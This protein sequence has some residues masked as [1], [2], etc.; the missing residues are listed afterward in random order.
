[1]VDV[2]MLYNLSSQGE[3]QLFPLKKRE[4][5]S[6]EQSIMSESL[7]T[8]ISYWSLLSTQCGKMGVME[9]LFLTLRH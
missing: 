4:Y 7:M 6:K 2:G 5:N 3:V 9:T 1:V 8:Y